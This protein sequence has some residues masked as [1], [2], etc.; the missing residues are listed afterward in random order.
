ML[1]TFISF[2]VPN[3]KFPVS[4]N[5]TK[6]HKTIQNYTKLT[7]TAQNCTKLHKRIKFNDKSHK[8]LIIIDLDMKFTLNNHQVSQVSQLKKP[9]VVTDVDL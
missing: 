2:L 4:Q 8:S 3:K 1:S 9:W 5:C 6:L 7:K